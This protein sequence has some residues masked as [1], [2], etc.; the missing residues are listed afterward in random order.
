MTIAGEFGAGTPGDSGFSSTIGGNVSNA[1]SLFS[2]GVNGLRAASTDSA[3]T[4][5]TEILQSALAAGG[6][7]QL[8]GAGVYEINATLHLYSNTILYIGAGVT[9][10]LRSGSTTIMF[11]N[12][13]RQATGVSVSAMTASGTIGSC[14]APDNTF[15]VGDFASITGPTNTGYAGVHKVLSAGDTFTVQLPTKPVVTTATGTITAT[16]PNVNITIF[17]PGT[18][19][20]N[21][22]EQATD[23][24]LNTMMSVFC[25]VHNLTIGDGLT[26]KN[27]NKFCAL[28][29]ASGY[30]RVKDCD[31]DSLSDGIHFVGPCVSAVCENLNGI[32][33]DDVVAFTIGDVPYINLSRGDFYSIA[34][35]NI[36]GVTTQLIARVSGNVGWEFYS[37]EFTNIRGVCGSSGIGIVDFGVDLVGTSFRK[38]VIDGISIENSGTAQPAISLAN[39][40]A[41]THGQLVIRNAEHKISNTSLVNIGANVTI[42][43]LTLEDVLSTEG[44]ASPV[45]NVAGTI[46]RCDVN[47]AKAV[48]LSSAFFIYVVA[49]TINRL[50]VRD[51]ELSGSGTRLI[52]QQ[53]TLGTVFIDGCDHLSGYALIEQNG[54]ANAGTQLFL[55][56]VRMT[57]LTSMLVGKKQAYL[58]TNNLYASG[59]G[60]VLIA[61]SGAFVL[62]WGGE[63]Y[64]TGITESSLAGGAT[65]T[66]LTVQI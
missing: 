41:A 33:G 43:R 19:D 27:A 11:D 9:L 18:I 15:A 60:G 42:N 36:Y 4:A 26:L 44:H 30:V 66:K 12:A 46:V 61:L 56:N 25:H 3:A 47:R 50:G 54:S 49:G 55:S 31:F 37:M 13:Q 17:G 20:A 51:V 65:I 34:C 1:Y 21:G 22:A 53:G 32:N 5:N 28:I 64:Y 29:A 58:F 39:T 52:A 40:T 63:G 10:K 24:T 7:V 23:G 35:N 57:S 59:F 2:G 38:C 62:S 48:M 16:V 8:L 6:R 45:L 14:V